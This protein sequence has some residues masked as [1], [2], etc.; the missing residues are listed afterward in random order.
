MIVNYLLVDNRLKTRAKKNF[1]FNP[2]ET[3]VYL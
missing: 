1:A 2:K 3:K